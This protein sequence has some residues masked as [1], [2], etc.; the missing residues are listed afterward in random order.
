MD[1][2]NELKQYFASLNDVAIAFSGGVDSAF[3]LYVASEVC[4]DRAV[5]ITATLSSLPK[6]ERQEAALF[7]R[8]YGIR[9]REVTIDEFAIEGYAQNPVDRCYIC[10]HRIFE[11]IKTTAAELN[12]LHV[13]EGSNIDDEG[14]YRPGLKALE[15]LGIESPLRKLGFTK[16]DI[17]KYSKMLGLPTWDKPALACTATRFAYGDIL[18]VEK[19][20]RVQEAER[21]LHSMGFTQLRA[22]V[23][24]SLLRLEVLPEQIN[25][26]MTNRENISTKMHE[27]GFDFVT[28][29]MDGFSSGSMNRLV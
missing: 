8:Q 25:L 6:E 18:T 24:G 13:C 21:Y 2:L 17:R 28:L 29:D 7:C 26:A 10:K 19:F 5:A 11:V 14:D 9:Q 15:E 16:E 22:R 23:H 20:T 4:G 27:L 12:L 3:L 1:K